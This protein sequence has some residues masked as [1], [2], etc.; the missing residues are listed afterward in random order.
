MEKECYTTTLSCPLGLLTLASNGSQL[1]GLWIENQKYFARTLPKCYKANPALPIFHE[2]ARWLELYFSGKRP[3]MQLPL[4]PE[5]SEFQQSVWRE[6]LSI[7]YGKTATYGQIAAK[8]G[9]TNYARAVGNA[10]GHNP[11][12]I[13]V[14]CHR[15]IGSDNLFTGY[16]GGL[17]KKKMLLSLEGILPSAFTAANTSLK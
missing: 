12:L 16:A 7:P 15:V 8:L 11:I 3:A 9:G 17:D 6:L 14:P 13:L 4:A 10:I 5:G 2:T 1:T